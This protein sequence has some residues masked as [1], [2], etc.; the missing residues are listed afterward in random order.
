MR[1]NLRL[2]KIQLQSFLITDKLW[3]FLFKM[4]MAKNRIKKEINILDS[5]DPREGRTPRDLKI[6][7]GQSKLID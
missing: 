2:L 5:F 1:T 3:Q 6:D 4:K 7:N